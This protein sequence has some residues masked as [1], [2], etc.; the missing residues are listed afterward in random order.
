MLNKDVLIVD[1]EPQMLIAMN[2]TLKRDGLSVTTASSGVEAVSKLKDARFR[3]VITDLRMPVVT[4]IDLLRE[5]KCCSP[6]TQVVL[7]TA[8][9]TVTNAV[10]AMKLGAF[11]YLLKPFSSGELRDVVRRAIRHE[12][13]FFTVRKSYQNFPIITQDP[14]MLSMLELAEQAAKGK[15]TILIQA[16]SGTG[17]ELLARWIHQTSP[18]NENS[19]VAVNCAA[20]PENLL[21]AELFGHEKGAF[22]GALTQKP[23]KFELANRGTILLDEIAE[24]V[25]LLQAKLLR[26]L[27]EQEVDRVGGSK[28]IPIDVRVIA[29]TNRDLAAMVKEG[30]FR[31]DLYYRLNVIPLTIPP[32]RKRKGDI[33]LL[34]NHFCEKYGL[35]V[36][37]RKEMAPETLRVLCEHDWRGNA[38]E[39]E[40]VVQRATT[41]ST[42]STIYPQD[43]FL[44]ESL[45][46]SQPA[47]SSELSQEC[48]ETVTPQVNVAVAHL[49]LKA[50]FSM[51][52]M[53]ERLIHLT[54]AETG[55]NR[56]RA[57]QLLGISLRTLRNKLREYRLAQAKCNSA[58]G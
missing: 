29:T 47:S 4:G 33:T 20:L 48:M 17:K 23:G 54:L 12:Q 19:F 44:P 49:N 30:S 56:T 27:Q 40:N 10:E 58:I 13:G 28:P 42:N 22:T 39:L 31:E 26:V 50:G 25:P 41:L 7:V 18:R 9:G 43:L 34:A 6:R 1:D 37:Y 45:R 14:D 16:E 52:E 11:D 51:S 35:Q 53:E 21:E 2:E 15:S 36:G 5:A 46:S 57:A 32:L 24:M 55:G 38:R 3:L 8:H